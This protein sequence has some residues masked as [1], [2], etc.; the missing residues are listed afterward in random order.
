MIIGVPKEIKNHENRVGL[1]PD[2]VTKITASG[3][4]VYIE[5]NAGIGSGFKDSEYIKARAK[6]LPSAKS[7]YKAS[8]MIVK[9]KEPL[10]Q[11]FAL[12]QTKQIIFTYLHLAAEKKLTQFL[13]KNKVA[14]IAYETVETPDKHLPLLEPMSQVAG[15][16]SIQV[17]A[18]FLEKTHG[19]RGVLLGGTTDVLPANVVVLGYGIAGSNAVQMARGLGAN[20]LVFDV[21]QKKIK[22]INN[23]NNPLF[24][25]ELSNS[26]N[27]AK[28]LLEAD[29][30]VGAVLIPGAKAPKLVTKKMIKNMQDGS[31]IV[32]IAIDQGGSMETSEPTNH[33]HPIYKVFGVTHYC[34][35]NMPGAVART[36]TLALT[37]RTLPYI[38]ELAN[39]GFTKAIK[40]NRDLAKGVNT[41][42][43]KLTCQGV[44]NA[45]SL[46]CDCVEKII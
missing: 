10:A 35:T 26:S 41:F 29:L 38:L 21:D 12:I 31:V 2:G 6:I 11:E 20:V 18:H 34:V 9:I 36:S 17:G 44:A 25:A 15:R 42:N 39:K 5:H 1:T 37:A 13:L 40:D 4:T 8:E 14:G 30:V 7:V 23:K 32:D 3:H 28:A 45:F 43:G 46:P 16:M 22:Q 27:I 24:K 33:E 19:G